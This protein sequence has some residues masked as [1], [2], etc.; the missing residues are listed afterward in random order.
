MNFLYYRTLANVL[1][2]NAKTLKC[3]LY[4]GRKARWTEHDDVIKLL[5]TWA[6]RLRLA[7][8]PALAR[9]GPVCLGRFLKQ[10]HRPAKFSYTFSSKWRKKLG[11]LKIFPHLKPKV[12]VCLWLKLCTMI[13]W[14]VSL[15]AVIR[16][17]MTGVKGHN[18]PVAESL[19]GRRKV[20][21]M[22]QVLHCSTFASERH[23]VRTR[24]LQTCFLLRAP[25][26]LVTPLAVIQ[27]SSALY[28]NIK[29]GVAQWHNCVGYDYVS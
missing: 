25:S 24:M 8:G 22:S 6:P 29:W 3:A 1:N 18:S 7:L 9:A 16:N 2:S 14:G 12:P 28:M 4:H 5:L 26:N 19:R 11:E 10:N 20:P 15:S 23:Q 13:C 21:T 17:V 27:Y